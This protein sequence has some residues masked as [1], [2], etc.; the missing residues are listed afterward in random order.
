M[1]TLSQKE[2][3]QR[4][5]WLLVVLLILNFGLMA[6]DARDSE[7]KQRTIRVWVQTLAAPAQN[8]ATGV[9]DTGN[10][11][12]STIASWRTAVGE[13]QQLHERVGQL[14]GEVIQNKD[15]TLENE[16]LKG[17]LKLQNESG[18][19]TVAAQVIARDPSVWFDT[20]TIN[21][22]RTHGVEL[23]MPVVTS[24][25][26]VGRVVATSLVT[27]QV[28]LLTN[29]KSAVG[30]VVGQ[31]GESNALGIVR[32]LG[33]KGLLEMFYV[34]GQEKVEVGYAITTTGQDKIFPPN[35]KVGE[36]VEVQNGS[37]SSTHKIFVRPSV[38]TGELHEVTV[39]LYRAPENPVPD[40]LL[41]NTKPQGDGKK[42]S[43]R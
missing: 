19:K 16:R 15:L 21:R 33:A 43:S 14:E 30:A 35:L 28:S 1:S 11:F 18:Y 3:R 12:F 29:D 9:G 17:L 41:P 34:S 40:Q 23:Y 39:L 38:S 42:K 32:G 25:G 6:Y 27:A 31:F 24:K 20:I 26:L 2:I 22:G 5:P 37:V 7:T 13:N 4:T 8:V 10:G 36:I